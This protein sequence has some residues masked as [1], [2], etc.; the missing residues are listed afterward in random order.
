MQAELVR[1]LCDKVVTQ[2]RPVVNNDL[3]SRLLLRFRDCCHSLNLLRVSHPSFDDSCFY[4][5]INFDNFDEDRY[6]RRSEAGFRLC[7]QTMAEL[8]VLSTDFK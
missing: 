3:H 7:R 1:A 6:N 4:F 5:T 8:E 2:M